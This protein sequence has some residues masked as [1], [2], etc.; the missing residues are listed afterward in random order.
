M[1]KI[2]ALAVLAI[3][4]TGCTTAQYASYATSKYCGLPAP[5]RMANREAVALATAPHRVEIEC[6]QDAFSQ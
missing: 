4:V 6:A 1:K 2:I 5:A 3:T